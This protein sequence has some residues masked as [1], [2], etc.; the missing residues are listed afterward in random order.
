MTTTATL[1]VSAPRTK[2]PRIVEVPRPGLP[3][4]DFCINIGKELKKLV[5]VRGQINFW[6]SKTC[7]KQPTED[8]TFEGANLWCVKNG[9]VGRIIPTTSSYQVERLVF[10]PFSPEEFVTVADEVFD[11]TRMT[12]LGPQS[13]SLTTTQA[14]I[15]LASKAV[16]SAL[17]VVDKFF[18]YSI[19]IGLRTI[20]AQPTKSLPKRES[21]VYCPVGFGSYIDQSGDLIHFYCHKAWKHR[22]KQDVAV[23]ILH[24]LYAGFPFLDTQSEIRAI[25]HLLTPYVQSLIGWRRKNPIWLF[26][27]NGPR[28]GKDYLGMVSPIINEGVAIQDPP[29]EEES[30]FKRRITS[31]IVG[32]RRFQHFANCRGKLESP[33]LEAAI[34]SEF[35]SDRLI[36][37]SEAPI[38]PNEIIYSMSYNGELPITPDLMLR[39]RRVHLDSSKGRIAPPRATR[40]IKTEEEPEKSEEAVTP[41]S[42]EEVDGVESAN[43]RKFQIADLHSRLASFTPLPKHGAA[44]E[45]AICRRNVFAAMRSL[46]EHWV[47]NPPASTPIFTSFP[48]WAEVV[49]GI[50][51]ANGLGNPTLTSSLELLSPYRGINLEYLRLGFTFVLHNVGAFNS[52]D[53]HDYA[54]SHGKAF[55]MITEAGAMS[56]GK[57]LADWERGDHPG[58]RFL[59]LHS[60][61]GNKSDPKYLFTVRD[62]TLLTR[63]PDFVGFL[64]VPE[65]KTTSSTIPTTVSPSITTS[66]HLFGEWPSGDAWLEAYH[67]DWLAQAKTTPYVPPESGGE[68]PKSTP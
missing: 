7:P 55:A 23:A 17:P 41:D 52:K 39:S 63:Y 10:R 62:S 31:A 57:K 1:T 34:T 6:D 4:A 24:K 14:K 2:L 15:V 51:I 59:T 8:M 40:P 27:A 21:L 68:A 65:S 44:S 33:S 9:I 22:V 12:A 53:F 38:M 42:T 49:G 37:T 25:A 30:E 5:M 48:D 3:I 20:P 56:V 50:M 46:V 66:E 60:V 13:T 32:G 16:K 43:S 28:A 58:S 54:Q 11:F 19:P 36:G 35:W 61:G 29:I 45:T 67:E 47:E 26:T 64:R 18:L